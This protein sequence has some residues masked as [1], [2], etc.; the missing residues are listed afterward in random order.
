M[1]T[2]PVP[3]S[4]APVPT[5]QP[6]MYPQQQPPPVP[7]S[8]PM[9]VPGQA[10]YAMPMG[11]QAPAAAPQWYGGSAPPPPP[12]PAE[13]VVATYAAPQAPVDP[14]APLATAVPVGTTY[15]AEPAQA[16][17]APVASSRSVTQQAYKRSRMSAATPIVAALLSVLVLASVAFI[18]G[19]LE[20]QE[21]AENEPKKPVRTPVRPTQITKKNDTPPAPRPRP[22][23]RPAPPSPAPMPDPMPEPAPNPDPAPMP[24]PMPEP[25]PM[26]TPE[27]PAPMPEPVPEPVKLPTR[28]EVQMLATAMKTARDALTDGNIE[29]A[30]EELAKVKGLTKLPKH[31]AMYDRLVTLADYN[32]QFWNAVDEAIKTFESGTEISV[33]SNVI[34]VVE[35]RPPD[36]IILRVAGRNRTYRV[37]ELPAGIAAAFADL[38]FDQQNPATRVMK[39]AYAAVNR[40]S[41]IERARE[42][43]DEATAQG[44]DMSSL[45]PVLDDTYDNLERDLADAMN[46]SAAA[47]G[48]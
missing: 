14:M 17:P 6:A 20:E 23:P 42:F 12:P 1:P 48:E 44:E 30:K 5:A 38:W 46:A 29:I 16:E 24:M 21:L 2:S 34:V 39:G 15:A 22:M 47:T 43:W 11:W 3:M 36:S 18:W 25:E 10:P 9:A 27:P 37:R 19:S 7:G 45:M 33:G 41:N 32:A 28:E 8:Y 26:P 40:A 4:P 35:V 31:A 13:P